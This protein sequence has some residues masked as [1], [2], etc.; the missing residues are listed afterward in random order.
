[1]RLISLGRLCAF[2]ALRLEAQTAFGPHIS[3]STHSWLEGVRPGAGVN[4][5]RT[6]GRQ[7]KL[8]FNASTSFPLPIEYSS[9][10]GGPRMISVGD[11]TR[12]QM[13][14]R[15]WKSHQQIQAGPVIQIRD[16]TFDPNDDHFVFGLIGGI[17]RRIDVSKGKATI[18]WSGDEED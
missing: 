8:L 9:E 5:E 12:R 16:R 2:Y 18:L 3:I 17:H 6:I 14:L 4:I 13:N 15:S 7:V 11:T 1:M 10:S